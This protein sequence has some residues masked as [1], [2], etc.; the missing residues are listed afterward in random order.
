MN[1]KEKILILAQVFIHGELVL[2][3]CARHKAEH[4]DRKG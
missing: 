1:L 3:V 2:L 4:H